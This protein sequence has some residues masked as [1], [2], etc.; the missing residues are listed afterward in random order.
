MPNYP[1]FAL[2]EATLT[3]IIE[4]RPLMKLILFFKVQFINT[5]L[6]W[7]AGKK[8]NHLDKIFALSRK[9]LQLAKLMNSINIH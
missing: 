8:F 5:N 3:T 4:Q 6:I 9:L 2:I 1:H 7:D